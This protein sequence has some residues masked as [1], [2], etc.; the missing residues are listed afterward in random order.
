M[1]SLYSTAYRFFAEDKIALDFAI[2]TAVTLGGISGYYMREIGLLEPLRWRGIGLGFHHLL[3]DQGT[4]LLS[5]RQQT[6]DSERLWK[7][8]L[9]D[10]TINVRMVSVEDDTQDIDPKE[11]DPWSDFDLTLIA[12]K[13]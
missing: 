6:A 13:V 3:L 11:V 12:S 10:P 8:L 4:V 7:K 1:M 2:L 9:A 5:G